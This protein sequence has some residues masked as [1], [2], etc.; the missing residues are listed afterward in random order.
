MARESKAKKKARAAEIVERLRAEYPDADCALHWDDPLQLLIAV[1]LSAQATDEGVNK[2]TPGL[3][4]RFPTAR[5]FADVEVEELQDAIRTI[6]LFRN[7]AKNIKAACQMIA[8]ERGGD[9]PQTMEELIELPGV[10]RKT[11]NVVLGTAFGVAS[12]IVVDTH[13]TR[14]S[15]RLGFTKLLNKNAV[16]IERNLVEVFAPDDWILLG[17]A[18]ILHGRQVCTARK[19]NCDECCLNDLC[20]KRGVKR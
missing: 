14:L 20:P 10:A 6:G 15:Q 2:L 5:D 16:I 1:I 13:V 3:F 12:G 17:H 9:V 8:D 18:L 7:K 11:A 4:E 19:P